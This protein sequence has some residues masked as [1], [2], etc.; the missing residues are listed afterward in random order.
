[1]CLGLPVHLGQLLDVEL[2]GVDELVQVGRRRRELRQQGGL[3]AQFIRVVTHGDS[4][5]H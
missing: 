2:A 3:V 5:F 4:S 1:M